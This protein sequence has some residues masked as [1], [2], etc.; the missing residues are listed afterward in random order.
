MAER[1]ASRKVA[2][3]SA[4]E[5]RDAAAD[6]PLPLDLPAAMFTGP[7]LLA[8][9]DLVPVMT[10]FVDRGLRYRF[11]NKALAEWFERPRRDMIGKHVREVLG[12]AAFAERE[13]MLR[14]ALAGERKLFAATF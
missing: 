10:A 5:T 2:D 7:G 6:L 11:M 8:L 13:P 3:G 14:A 12:E 1:V 4:P 9:A